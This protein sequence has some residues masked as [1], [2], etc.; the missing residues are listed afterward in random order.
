MVDA[1]AAQ[2]P[3]NWTQVWHSAVDPSQPPTDTT[4]AIAPTGISV[5]SETIRMSGAGQS[6]TYVCTF[7]TPM[8]VIAWPPVVG[9][10]F[11]G[12]ATCT[13][14]SGNGSFTVHATGSISGTQATNDGGAATTAYVVTTHVTTSGQVTSTATENDWF[15]PALDLD[16]HQDTAQSGNYS[17]FV[18]FQSQ[19]TRDLVSTKP[20]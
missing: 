9:H 11:S 3:G 14:P 20:A 16:L 19:I 17:G 10:S 12:T 1:A 5:V 8:Q 4:F 15:D 2:G 18:N 7:S 13:Q 6:I